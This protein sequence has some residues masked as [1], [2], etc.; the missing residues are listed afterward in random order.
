MNAPLRLRYE[1]EGF[2][3][4]L[5]NYWAE[6]A[7]KEFVIG[8]V[9]TL[10]EHHERSTATHNHY[11]AS[12]TEGWRNLPDELLETYPTPEHL[13]KRALIA[14]G[15][16]DERTIVCSSKAE[17]GR[18]AAFVKPMDE[19]AVVS[20]REAVVRVWTAKSQSMKAMGKA[21]FAESKNAVLDFIAD[22]LGVTTDELAKAAA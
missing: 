6:R 2:F 15:Y 12:I 5:S 1:G 19:Y 7:D 18:V 9:Y 20:V 21:E 22:L 4:V 16:R 14:K 3:R 11:F 17:A 10:V 13:R 8:E